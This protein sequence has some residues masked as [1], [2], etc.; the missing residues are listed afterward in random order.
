MLKFVIGMG[1]GL[2]AGYLYGSERARDEAR[3]RLGSMPEPVRQA[4]DYISGSISNTPLPDSFKQTAN[5][6]TAAVQSATERA[7]QAASPGGSIATP[8]PT[9]VASR[10]SEPLPRIEPETR[11]V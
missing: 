5:R 2:A 11:S 7:A 3:R 4:T 10:P 9:E 8:T 1:I 6:A